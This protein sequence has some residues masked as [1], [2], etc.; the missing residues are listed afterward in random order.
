MLEEEIRFE[1]EQ[2][3]KK[4]EQENLFSTEQNSRIRLDER[5]MNENGEE[6]M[7]LLNFTQEQNTIQNSQIDTFDANSPAEVMIRSE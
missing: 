4:M 6:D 2:E 7:N 5:L 1:Q 3:L